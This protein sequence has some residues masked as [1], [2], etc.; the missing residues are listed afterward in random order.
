MP[1]QARLDVPGTL[2]HV[3]IRGIE[4]RQIVDDDKDRRN[5]VNRLGTLA[6]ETNTAI[7][8]WALMTNHAH[9]LLRSGP[10][11]LS[12]FMKR[13]L[14]GYGVFYNRRHRRHGH[15]F[16]NRFK[17]IVVEEDSYFQVI[18]LGENVKMRGLILK[19]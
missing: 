18:I 12:K 1:R 5:F 9:I 4:Q 6:L 10:V 7:Y 15:L 8:A 17:S 11:G 13:F 2:H 3:I 19:H 16:Q 14:T